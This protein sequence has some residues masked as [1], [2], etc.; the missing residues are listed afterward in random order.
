MKSSTLSCSPV[1]LLE[2][3]HICLRGLGLYLDLEDWV[4]ESHSAEEHEVL[5][6]H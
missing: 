5:G 1:H 3:A 6:L 2:K 4:K